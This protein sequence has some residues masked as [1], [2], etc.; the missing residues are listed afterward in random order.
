MN[1]NIIILSFIL[2]LIFLHM[3]TFGSDLKV[4]KEKTFQISPGKNL[5][6]EASSGEVLISSWDKNEVYIKILGNQK[7][8]DKVKFE[9]SNDDNKVEVIAKR[10]HWLLGWFESGVRLKF[11]IKVPEKFN[12]KAGTGGGNVYAKDISGNLDISTSGGNIDLENVKGR[13]EVSTS[14]GNISG[15]DFQGDLDAS[16]SGGSLDLTGSNSKIKAT[17]SG[18][19]IYLDYKGINK[20]IYLSTS[21]GSIDIRLPEDFNAAANLSTS[22][23][24][25]S[26]ELTA[27]NA[28]KI[29]ST[30]FIAD[31]NKGGNTLIAETSGGNITVKG[32]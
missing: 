13:F 4:I 20:G 17:T 12:V 7:A 25:V 14:G 1:K 15:I 19:N 21:G 30:E 29:S 31:L 18:G 11:E 26:C 22:G 5:K 3:D 8:E 6:V 10:K 23:G 27:N 32:K 2:I 24:R 16:T 28:R 9:F